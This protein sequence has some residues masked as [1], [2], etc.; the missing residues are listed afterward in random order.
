MNRSFPN[1][2]TRKFG[3]DEYRV[4]YDAQGY[5]VRIW[6]DSRQGYIMN[7]RI[8]KTLKEVSARLGTFNAK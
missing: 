7:G 5:A 2:E 8:Y 6:G 1:I 3:R 4:G